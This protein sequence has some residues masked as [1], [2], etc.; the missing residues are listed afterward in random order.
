MCMTAALLLAACNSGNS[1]NASG[2]A[3]QADE[4]Q[5]TERAI[6]EAT[7][8]DQGQDEWTKQTTIMTAKP[9]VIDC[10]ATW[11]GPC[12]Q[13]APLLDEIEEQYKG[14]V[15]F[16]RIDVDEKPDLAQEFGI[17]AIPTLMFVTPRGEYQTLVG[18]NERAVIEAKVDAL[19]N[20][21]AR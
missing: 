9:M 19:L 10:Y 20:R 18:L 13:L 4:V 16:E 1:D 7:A 12:K 14:K 17:Q 11:C 21:S 3:D 8:D 15:I 2:T 5:T 6:P